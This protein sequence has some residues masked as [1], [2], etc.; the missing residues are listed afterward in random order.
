MSAVAT[1][2]EEEQPPLA[3]KSQASANA[4]TE[5]AELDRNTEGP[6]ESA[7]E[8]PSPPIDGIDQ[9]HAMPSG[10][11]GDDSELPGTASSA[12]VTVDSARA[13]ASV[14]EGGRGG[15]SDSV[16]ST[17]HM[18]NGREKMSN[19][20]HPPAVLLTNPEKR[21]DSR[22]FPAEKLAMEKAKGV[23]E[24]MIT[25]LG[26]KLATIIQ[27]LQP[28]EEEYKAIEDA[29]ARLKE[30]YESLKEKVQALRK[31]ADELLDKAASPEESEVE[32]LKLKRKADAKLDEAKSLS[33]ELSS[34]ASE[35]ERAKLA[36]ESRETQALQALVQELGQQRATV[37]KE[38]KEQEA[39]FTELGR[40]L[41][42]II[43][44]EA[45]WLSQR[46][47]VRRTCNCAVM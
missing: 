30:A 31:E 5:R 19:G 4:G 33:K 23:A 46:N 32:A 14:F 29:A 2:A 44:D 41:K 24:C 38:L 3:D 1:E 28:K 9:K 16:G 7:P 15:G 11:T 10:A 27:D 36:L 37:E 17:G 20:T 13:A 35:A 22:D 39:H 12:L 40:K 21:L 43:D 25:S 34:R 45:L 8:A 18:P 47:C 6:E 26:Q 42:M